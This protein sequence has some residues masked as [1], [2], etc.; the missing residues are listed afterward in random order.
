MFTNREMDK[1]DVIYIYSGILPIKRKEIVSLAESWMGL[2]PVIKSEV[3][4]EEKSK[5][6]LLTY[7][8][9]SLEI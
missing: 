1:E 6:C 5:Y 4:Q 2:E 7:I 3:S 8:M 9:W